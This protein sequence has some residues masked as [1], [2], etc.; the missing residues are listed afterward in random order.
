MAPL[1]DSKAEI[2]DDSALI[3]SW[4]EALEEYKVIMS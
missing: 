1:N 4:D 2:W 3:D